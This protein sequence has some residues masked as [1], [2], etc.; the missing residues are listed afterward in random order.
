M[1]L[2][3]DMIHWSNFVEVHVHGFTMLWFLHWPH[4]TKKSLLTHKNY[5]PDPHSK[6]QTGG[7][8]QIVLLS[9]STFGCY[10]NGEKTPI[11]HLTV[12][13]L[14]VWQY[15]WNL[16]FADLEF[17]TLFKRGNLLM[18][19]SR[20]LAT[21]IFD[22]APDAQSVFVAKGSIFFCQWYAVTDTTNI[23]DSWSAVLS[24]VREV[25]T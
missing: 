12:Q 11:L 10:S 14:D 8:T 23:S 3:N 16:L 9:T 4:T 13:Q 2:F 18:P 21:V 15:W 19:R 25:T 7:S 22:P 5:L 17:S 1:V 24:I 20:H 6:T